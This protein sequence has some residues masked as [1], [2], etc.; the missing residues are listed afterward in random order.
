[1]NILIL[2]I[3]TTFF[4]SYCVLFWQKISLFSSLASDKI[5]YEHSYYQA[6]SLLAYARAY[7]AAHKHTLFNKDPLLILTFATWPEQDSN[8]KQFRA[9]IIFKQESSHITITAQLFTQEQK[10]LHTLEIQEIL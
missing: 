6:K 7:V 8:H 9:K 1:M 10:I 4:T 5:S 3:C 2:I